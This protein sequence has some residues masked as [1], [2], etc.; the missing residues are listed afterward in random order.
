MFD[1]YGRQTDILHQFHVILSPYLQLFSRKRIKIDTDWKDEKENSFS[2]LSILLPCLH[3][4]GVWLLN[5]LTRLHRD[6]E[7]VLNLI[8]S[9]ASAVC[10]SHYI[11]DSTHSLIKYLFRY[12]ILSQYPELD[13]FGTLHTY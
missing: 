5:S 11:S 10:T 1:R 6:V 13:S 12:K 3:Y 2:R 9:V 7:V 8:I 4:I